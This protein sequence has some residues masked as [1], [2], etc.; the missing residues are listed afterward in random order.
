MITKLSHQMPVVQAFGVGKQ[1]QVLWWG[2]AL[3]SLLRFQHLVKDLGQYF[4]ERRV[5]KCSGL[6][7]RAHVLVLVR[8]PFFGPCLQVREAAA[9]AGRCLQGGALELGGGLTLMS[10]LSSGCCCG[11]KGVGTLAG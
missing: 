1:K 7:R 5:V 2:D 8:S 3:L 6:G 10:L 4:R 9:A 11:R